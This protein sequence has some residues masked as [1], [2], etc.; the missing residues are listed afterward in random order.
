MKP[1]FV[2]YSIFVLLIIAATSALA[3][4]K[5]QKQ[6]VHSS[7]YFSNS[8][9]PG[10]TKETIRTVIDNIEYK[11]EMVNEK[12]TE[13]YIDGKLIPAGQYSQYETAISKIKEQ[14]RLDKI[15]AKKDQEQAM[16]D[17]KL[18][19]LDQE[20]AKQDQKQA[21]KDQDEAKHM[22]ELSLQ[23]QKKAK[24]NQEKASKDQAQAKL[25]QEQA[26]KNQATAKIDQQKAEED[27][28]QAKLNQERA[29]K[30]QLQAKLD[31]EQAMKD[32][33]L[34]KIDQKNAAED[35]RLV[36]QLIGDLIKDGVVTDEKNLFS[37]VISET[38]MTVNN[39][40]QPNELYEKYK[41]KYPRFAT[42][43]FS[44]GNSQNGNKTIHMNR[45]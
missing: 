15:Q 19:V 34:A 45:P 30:D 16:R 9:E 38:E 4:Q 28:V 37:I 18:A 21:M 25:D 11:M 14:L 39:K 29:S 6:K 1:E 35:Q 22:R 31:Q 42:G 12:I 40:K 20:K 23:D 24:L 32:Q 41:T 27:Q 43:H 5:V 44:Y 33:A 26:M 17:Q 10:K 13:L 8:D 2:K 36:N 7:G 3:Q